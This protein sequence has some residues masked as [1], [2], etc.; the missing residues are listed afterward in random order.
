MLLNRKLALAILFMGILY[1]FFVP[2]EPIPVK[3]TFKIIPML[4]IILYAFRNMIEKESKFSWMIIMGLVFCMLGD[5]LLIWFVVGLSSFLIGHL[6]YAGGFFSRWTFSWLRFLTLLPI[7]AY[8][9]FMGIHLVQALQENREDT[10][11]IPVIFYIFVI[12]LMFWSA[13]MTGNIWA[14]FGSALFVISDSLLSW[15]KF[16]SEIAFSGELIMIT[17]YTAQFLIAKSLS[18]G[19]I[20]KYPL[21]SSKNLGR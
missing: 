8:S 7:A 14:I 11:I 5:G 20:N 17:Y 2:E 3:I 9:I 16:I 15:N 19:S 18:I 10:L 6:F 21:L 1:I 4:L 12:S 13:I